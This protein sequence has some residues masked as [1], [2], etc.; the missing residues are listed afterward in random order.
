MSF[1]FD[2]DHVH[3]YTRKQSKDIQ[4]QNIEVERRKI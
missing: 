3:G 4:N 2:Y 1:L